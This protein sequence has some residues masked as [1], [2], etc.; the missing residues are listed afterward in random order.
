VLINWLNYKG[1]KLIFWVF[2]CIKY[3]SC[4]YCFV[5]SA[6]L[7]RA[8][9][10]K[11]RR[12]K[13]LPRNC[14]RCNYVG[15]NYQ[16]HRHLVSKHHI[17]P[18]SDSDFRAAVKADYVRYGYVM[19]SE[20]KLNNLVNK[21]CEWWWWWVMSLETGLFGYP[22]QCCYDQLIHSFL[23]SNYFFVISVCFFVFLLYGSIQKDK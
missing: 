13:G 15:T 20:K 6:S 16:L 22:F 11:K 9:G 12:L 1:D 4:C 7:P 5:S 10:Y 14:P 8:S 17:Y 3:L 18:D 19:P 2:W 21:L 23:Y